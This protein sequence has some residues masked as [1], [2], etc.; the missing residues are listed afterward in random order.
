MR[1]RLLGIACIATWHSVRVHIRAG[2]NLT[3]GAGLSWA[4]DHDD[5][6]E[7]CEIDLSRAQFV[8]TFGLVL[9]V[10]VAEQAVQSN[11][12][13]RVTSPR[14]QGARVWLSRMHLRE[15]LA[16]LGVECDLKPVRHTPLGDRVLELHSFDRDS[17]D[18]LAD[19]VYRALEGDDRAEAGTL[20]RSVADA[21]DNVRCH[22]EA[23]RGWAALHQY[24]KDATRRIEFAVGDS[25]VGL[26]RSLAAAHQ[27]QS[28]KA[29]LE[30][31]L[32]RGISGTGEA[33]RGNGLAD[34]A[35]RAWKRDGILR[36]YSGRDVASVLRE[37]VV[38][39]RPANA[40]FPG[41][42]VYSK[43]TFHHGGD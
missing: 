27:V 18:E 33:G 4:I 16:E 31:A 35:E 17:P 22:S 7:C 25:G 5:D 38:R 20:Y 2:M 30:L 21:L 42:L 43:M 40:R 41:T 26:R 12:K 19:K 24:G 8:D 23:D 10:T 34:I 11:Q 36:L 3:A 9:V 37:S 15:A 32:Q 6:V 13:V 28:D 14:S 29:A 1:R 39:F